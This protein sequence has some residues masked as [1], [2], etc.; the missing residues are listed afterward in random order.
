MNL[1]DITL[2]L[3]LAAFALV[4][5]LSGDAAK[6]AALGLA[7]IIFVVS[8]GLLG[9]TLAA[10]SAMSFESNVGWIDSPAIR[11]HTGIDGVSVW[12]ILLAAVCYLF[13]PSIPGALASAFAPIFQT[14][15]DKYY[16]DELY[17]VSIVKPI[18]NGS[19]EIL[20]KG[21]D[22]GVFDALVNGA[23]TSSLALGG[24]LRR[25][26]SGNLR[27]YASWV[28]IGILLVMGGFAVYGGSK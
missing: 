23:G 17:D 24:L 10:P 15:Y 7:L 9:P 13:V 5:F 3:P 4:L 12:L 26:Q 28:L 18:A 21:A 20:W 14:L 2:I 22:V 16:V 6:K 1:L 19:R 11:Y 27:T 8:L 25:M